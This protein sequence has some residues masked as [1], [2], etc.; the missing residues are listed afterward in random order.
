[1]NIHRCDL[2]DK[3]FTTPI[4]NFF[5]FMLNF[6]VLDARGC[7]VSRKRNYPQSVDSFEKFSTIF[8]VSAEFSD[9]L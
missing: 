1:M 3:L 8:V 7:I 5:P 6:D 2:V 9:L 4:F